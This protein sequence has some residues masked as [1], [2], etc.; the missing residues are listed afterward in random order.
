MPMM[1]GRELADAS[2]LIRPQLKVLYT[3]GYT[4]N[5]IVHGGRPRNRTGQGIACDA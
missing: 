2:H 5:V 3:R 4:R 1:S